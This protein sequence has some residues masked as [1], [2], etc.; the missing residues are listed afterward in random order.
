MALEEAQE[1]VPLKRKITYDQYND[2][3]MPELQDEI[4]GGPPPMKKA[5]VAEAKP[6]SKAKAKA[7]A[8]AKAKAA[9]PAEGWT[10]AVV[11]E[12]KGWKVWQHYNPEGKTVYKRWQSPEGDF[13]RTMDLARPAGFPDE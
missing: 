13:Y 6:K 1:T 5:K 3:K 10:R 7:K 8:I 2:M 9:A 12:Q 11:S 4:V